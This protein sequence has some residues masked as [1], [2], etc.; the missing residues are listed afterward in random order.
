MGQWLQM[1]DTLI[2]RSL[3]AA[4]AAPYESWFGNLAQPV[5]AKCSSFL[6][7]LQ[8]ASLSSV[9]RHFT[10]FGWELPKDYLVPRFCPYPFFGA[11]SSVFKLIIQPG[12]PWPATEP[13]L[14]D[15][16]IQNLEIL[17]SPAQV[18]GTPQQKQNM[19]VTW[20]FIYFHSEH[21]KWLDWP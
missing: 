2:K 16:S 13:E 14:Q 19:A 21:E 5:W 18:Q 9:D 1:T 8:T 6:W 10:R 12:D 4:Q 15:A 20:D 7:T 3:Q 11:F 17:L